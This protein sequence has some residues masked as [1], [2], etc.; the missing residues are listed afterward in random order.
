MSVGILV[1]STSNTDKSK[2]SA[3]FE[4]RQEDQHA[5]DKSCDKSCE[6]RA[7]RAQ[8]RENKIGKVNDDVEHYQSTWG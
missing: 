4:N 7:D 3:S 1:L 2:S 5:G 8:K 6:G